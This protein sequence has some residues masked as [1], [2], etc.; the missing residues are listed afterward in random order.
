MANREITRRCLHGLLQ[1]VLL[2]GVFAVGV[3]ALNVD[4]VGSIEESL[5][6]PTSLEVFDNGLAVLEPFSDEIKL[7]TVDGVITQKLHLKGEPHGLTHIVNNR[8]MFCDRKQQAVIEVDLDNYSEQVLL[9][10]SVSLNDPVDLVQNGQTLYILDA[11]LAA[12]LEIG[13]ALK[14]TR[15]IPLVDDEGQRLAYASSFCF[16]AHL[17]RFYVLDQINSRISAFDETGA[18]VTSFGSFGRGAGQFTRGGELALSEG[19]HIFV[20]DRF[21]GRVL[22][23][24]S[25]GEFAGAIGPVS[26]GEPGLAVPT[27]IDVDEN[28][29]LFVASTMT[30]S[31]NIYHVALS[32]DMHRLA[33]AQPQFPLDGAQLSAD[34]ITIIAFAD[35]VSDGLEVSGFDF[36]LF[37]HPDSG[38]PLLE[39]HGVEGVLHDLDSLQSQRLIANW[40]PDT[41]LGSDVDYCWRARTQ[42]RDTVGEWSALQSFRLS[43]LPTEFRLDQNYPNPFNSGTRIGFSLPNRSNVTL[44]VFSLLG[45][46]VAVV[47]EGSLPE[48]YHEVTWNGADDNGASVATGVYF[49]R[50]RAANLVQTKKMVLLK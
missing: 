16:D 31:I 24:D 38:Q 29:L 2:V 41:R 46:R 32:P 30:P 34:E 50:L 47:H 8:F 4:Y 7:F 12:I 48:G 44:E 11:G 23:Y 3:G 36:Q 45:Q 5:Y 20:T 17:K 19:G 33:V 28:G 6:A 22:V 42:G 25:D 10:Q 21:Q 43:S 18:L 27:G 26:A 9:G 49:Y 15:T 1:V 13:A 35:I 14:L 40:T 37:D 39:L